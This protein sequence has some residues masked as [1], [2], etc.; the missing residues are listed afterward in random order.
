MVLTVV[1]AP[2]YGKQWLESCTCFKMDFWESEKVGNSLSHCFITS[3]FNCFMYSSHL[4][5]INLTTVWTSTI[6]GML[7]NSPFYEQR[8]PFHMLSVK[9]LVQSKGWVTMFWHTDT[10]WMHIQCIIYINTFRHTQTHVHASIMH[11]H[12]D[13]HLYGV[14]SL[15]SPLTYDY[16]FNVPYDPS[17]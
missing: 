6:N 17:K 3:T 12:R 7:L 4:L 8:H 1:T 11:I 15:C 13:K 9:A 2:L 16:L 10:L 5:W 14:L